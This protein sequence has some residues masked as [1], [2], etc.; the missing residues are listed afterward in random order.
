[1]YIIS[2]IGFFNIIQYPEDVPKGILTVKARRRQDLLSLQAFIHPELAKIGPADIEESKEA[3]Y[4]Y[5]L[6]FPAEAIMAAVGSLV[7]NIRYPKTKD[8]LR[9]THPDRMDTYFE[10]WDILSDLQDNRA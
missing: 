3:D 6:K 9:H 5:R 1:M 10:V 2:E 4:R 8:R 7:G